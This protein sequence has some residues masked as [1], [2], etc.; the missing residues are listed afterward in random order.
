MEVLLLWPIRSQISA[1][2]KEELPD[3]TSISTRLIFQE[4][5]MK[6]TNIKIT[7]QWTK[8]TV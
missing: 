8:G 3:K 1:V 4:K 6:E 2:Q 7:T 5:K